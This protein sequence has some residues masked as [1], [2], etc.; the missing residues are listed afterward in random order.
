MIG[1]MYSSHISDMY[2]GAG[3]IKGEPLTVPP[4]GVLY[5]S[6]PLARKVTLHH[7]RSHQV[8]AQIWSD[9]DGSFRF[10]DLADDFY[11][12]IAWDYLEDATRK[13]A[14]IQDHIWPAQD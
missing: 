14:G 2:Y 12:A 9:A 3:Y 10:D 8:L 6:T 4:S 1:R 7:E 13:R 11:Y 5:G